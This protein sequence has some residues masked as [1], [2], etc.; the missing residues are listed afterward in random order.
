MQVRAVGLTTEEE[1]APRRQQQR[2]DR[3][4]TAR[5]M[6]MI[7][8]EVEDCGTAQREDGSPGVVGGPVG[9]R[10]DPFAR[11][12]VVD[13]HVIRLK[14]LLSRT[15]FIWGKSS[16]HR[17]AELGEPRRQWLCHKRRPRVSTIAG[18]SL[19][20]ELQEVLRSATKISQNHSLGLQWQPL[21]HKVHMLQTTDQ[22]VRTHGL[23]AGQAQG[24][25]HNGHRLHPCI[26]SSGL[27]RAI[28]LGLSYEGLDAH[29]N[30]AARRKSHI[31]S[32]SA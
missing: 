6:R 18:S 13:E 8:P 19:A 1:Q 25:I 28:L 3:R 32:S 2:E 17:N 15:P 7:T 20:A 21:L 10:H 16:C 14:H 30:C 31:S 24:L 23:K 11:L 27:H 12:V 26:A 4:L 5:S 29:G 9:V 22:A